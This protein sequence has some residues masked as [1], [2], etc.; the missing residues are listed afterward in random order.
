[1][2]IP[3]KIAA[4]FAM[5][6][7]LSPLP[8]QADEVNVFVVFFE[9][10]SVALSP[11]AEGV[12]A[13]ATARA[14]ELRASRVEIAGFADVPRSDAAENE[15]EIERATVVSETLANLGIPRE[16]IFLSAHGKPVPVLSTAS[17][18]R[19]PANRRTEIIIRP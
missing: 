19:E 4:I 2:I 3:N 6:L 15:L 14:R 17:G 10:N 8:G 9:G 11:L 1:M 18:V 13:A 5:A 16:T 7:L 12:V